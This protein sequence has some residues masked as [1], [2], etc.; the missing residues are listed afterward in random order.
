MLACEGLLA[1]LELTLTMR[2]NLRSAIRGAARRIKRIGAITLRSHWYHQSESVSSSGG[3]TFIV[4]Q[5]L[6]RTSTREKC[7]RQSSTI[8]SGALA[9]VTS[10]AMK[11]LPN[12][13]ARSATRA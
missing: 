11:W 5:L 2:P 9:D 6:T 12:S 13:A 1:A 10:T 3:V 8:L 7:S 4:P